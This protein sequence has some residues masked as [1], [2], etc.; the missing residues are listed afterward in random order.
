MRQYITISLD[1]YN[2]EAD[3]TPKSQAIIDEMINEADLLDYDLLSD[4]H[5]IFQQAFDDMAANYHEKLEAMQRARLAK[6]KK[7]NAS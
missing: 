1:I 3:L 6:W 4:V 7:E 2:G 5:N